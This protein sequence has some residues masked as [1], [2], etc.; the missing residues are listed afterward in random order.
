M[1]HN[2]CIGGAAAV[3]AVVLF[4]FAPSAAE[5]PLNEAGRFVKALGDDAVN[6][7]STEEVGSVQR[8]A[9]YRDLLHRGFAID[10]IARFVLG[11][12]WR[13]ASAAQRRAYLTLFREYV[14]DVYSARLDRYSGESFTIL[15]EQPL[16]GKDTMVSTEIHSPDGAPIRVDYRVRALAGGHKVIDVL[17]EGVSLITTQRSEITSIIKRKGM[18]GLLE[19]LRERTSPGSSSN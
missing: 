8:N 5:I 13:A 7:L 6:V 2:R 9:R 12:N 11:R 14:L 18:D 15:K 19:L 3:L 1:S 17:V 10:I 16:D 4:A